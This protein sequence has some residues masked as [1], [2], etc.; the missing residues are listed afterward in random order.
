MY[1]SN[2]ESKPKYIGNDQFISS[3][4]RKIFIDIEG[5]EPLWDLIFLTID[6]GKVIDIIPEHETLKF[7]HPENKSLYLKQI[8]KLGKCIPGYIYNKQVKSKRSFVLV[9]Q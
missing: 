9:R 6:V 7:N 8:N 3:F 1:D 5:N 4:L 2:L